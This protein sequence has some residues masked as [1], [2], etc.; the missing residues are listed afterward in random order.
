MS[1]GDELTPEEQAELDREMEEVSEDIL[2]SYLDEVE[3]YSDFTE[4][5]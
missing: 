3:D 1:Y 4:P 5:R 2:N